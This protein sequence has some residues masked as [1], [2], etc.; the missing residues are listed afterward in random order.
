[1]QT[2]HDPAVRTEQIVRTLEFLK[3][4]FTSLAPVQN[5]NVTMDEKYQSFLNTLQSYQ[6]TPQPN[7]KITGLGTI[8]T[9]HKTN[10]NYIYNSG[11]ANTN[12]LVVRTP[13]SAA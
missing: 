3:E 8:L 13:D 11:S 6:I 2:T 1:M 5:K 4:I 10:I 12:N 9:G 7:V